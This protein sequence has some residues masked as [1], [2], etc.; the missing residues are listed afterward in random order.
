M[1]GS[2]ALRPHTIDILVL[3]DVVLSDIATPFDLFRH[4]R[5]SSGKPAYSVRLCG[6][7]K[8]LRSDEIMLKVDHDIRSLDAA[9]TLIVPGRYDAMAP[10]SKK[11]RHT[12]NDMAAAG[13]RIAS[14]CTGAC[15]LAEAGLLEGLNATT[16]WLITEQLANAYPSV[17]VDANKLYIDNGQILTSAG[18]AAAHDLCL[19][20]IQKD[21]GAAVAASAAR[22]AVMPLFREGGQS[23]FIDRKL[24]ASPRQRS[25]SPVLTWLESNHHRSLS[26]NDIARKAAMSPRTLIRRFNDELGITPIQW[27]NRCRVNIAQRLLEETHMNIEQIAEAAGFGSA[28]VFRKQFRQHVGM[29]A[30]A[31]RRSFR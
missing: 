5:T 3:D 26:L 7:G 9:D 27:L 31:Y 25:L 18:A 22:M 4:A 10:I 6:M 24:I 20:M 30:I 19:H 13:K 23:Q 29:S 17:N 2:I 16:H 8:S 11:L 28:S 15:V 14:I 1:T 12:L 21:Y